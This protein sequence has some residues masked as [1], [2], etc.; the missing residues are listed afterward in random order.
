MTPVFVDSS[1]IIRAV[2]ERGLSRATQRHLSS[3]TALVVSRLALVETS[4]ALLR[5]RVD[6][7]VEADA[8]REAAEEIDGLWSRC[9]IWEISRGVCD[10]ASRI[11]PTLALRTLDAIQLATFIVARKRMTTLRL[12]STDARMLDAA[13]RL[14]LR[15]I[16][17]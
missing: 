8:V 10:E 14:G 9:E 7:R 11:A 3:S 5:A 2:L 13:M 16:K 4:R 15:I 17:T 6:G 12:L 1:A